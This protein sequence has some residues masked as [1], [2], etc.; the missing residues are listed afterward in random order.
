MGIFKKEEEVVMFSRILIVF[1]FLF[2]NPKREKAPGTLKPA[3]LF[4]I[5]TKKQNPA[6]K[7]GFKMYLF[8]RFGLFARFSVAAAATGLVSV[9]SAYYNAF[10]VFGHALGKSGRVAAF[11]ANG[12][13]FHNKFRFSH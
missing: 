1:M 4:T 8:R 3:V 2:V 10:G 9:R 12:V 5:T 11:G 13:V 7:R 6:Y